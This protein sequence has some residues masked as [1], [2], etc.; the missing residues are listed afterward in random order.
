MSAAQ[1]KRNKQLHKIIDQLEDQIERLKTENDNLRDLI[2]QAWE[3]GIKRWSW[4]DHRHL[5]QPPK[6]G[7][8]MKE[9]GL[10]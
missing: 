2:P 5:L 9:K 7:E 1:Q 6:L 10:L 3:A 4:Y 8:W